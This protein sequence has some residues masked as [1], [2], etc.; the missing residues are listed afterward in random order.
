MLQP[1]RFYVKFS[2]NPKKE[3]Y[4]FGAPIPE[5]ALLQYVKMN[6]ET[7]FITVCENE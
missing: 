5:I 4:L 1:F 6:D 2:G 3:T 7:S